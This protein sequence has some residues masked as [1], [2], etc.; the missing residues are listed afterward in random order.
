MMDSNALIRMKNFRE[1]PVLKRALSKLI[2]QTRQQ[3]LLPAMAPLAHSNLLS[4]A[5][6]GRQVP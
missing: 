2:S 3:T 1:Q 4:S 6:A 5:A